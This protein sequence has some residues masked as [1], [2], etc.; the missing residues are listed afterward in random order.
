MASEHSPQPPL[1]L[2]QAWEEARQSHPSLRSAAAGTEA[3]RERIT[4]ASAWE[5]PVAGLELMRRGT[6]NPVKYSEVE[7]SLSQKIPLT[8]QRRLRTE[9][10]RAE[11]GMVAAE[12]QGAS[13]EL[14][15]DLVKAFHELHAAR[16][17]RRVLL[18]IEPLLRRAADAARARLA[19]GGVPATGVLLIEQERLRL[20]EELLGMDLEI[21]RAA[22]ELNSLRQR[23]L[24]EPIPELQLATAGEGDPQAGDLQADRAGELIAE[25]LSAR[26]S[27]RAA[28]ARITAAEQGAK[29]SRAWLPDPELMLKAR[30]MNGGTRLVEDYDTG[31]AVS[32][33]WFNRGRYRAAVRE[34]G[35]LQ[36]AAEAEAGVLRTRTAAELRGT[37]HELATARLRIQF[38]L[39]ERLPLAERLLSASLTGI[40]SGRGG[41]MELLE[42]RRSL[43]E[44]RNALT[45]ARVS[46]A[47]TAARLRAL[48]GRPAAP[49]GTVHA[50]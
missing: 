8:S 16:E 46:E 17:Q 23:P 18:E 19:E 40:D 38:L 45:L 28:E 30:H 31:I 41:V 2:R 27:L 48:L 13:F 39:T 12:E 6:R 10:A 35:A 33:P 21:A 14:Y 50:P 24:D 7:L 9:L 29:L 44:T 5:D 34:A 36:R 42:A 11:A 37:L 47:V 22:T 25:A 20:R 26:P 1:S 32:L 3:A 15:V 4:Q 49:A 43:S